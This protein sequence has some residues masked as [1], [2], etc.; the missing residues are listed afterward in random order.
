MVRKRRKKMKKMKRWRRIRRR[1]R[2]WVERKLRYKV[3]RLT[4][5]AIDS[6]IVPVNALPLKSLSR[7]RR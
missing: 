7:K 6:G 5:L 2:R 1:E 4:R 3:V